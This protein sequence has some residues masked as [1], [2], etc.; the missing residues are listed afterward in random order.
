MTLRRPLA[1]A[2]IAVTGALALTASLAVLPATAAPKGVP[3]GQARPVAQDVTVMTRNIYLGGDITR[4][5]VAATPG[6]PLQTALVLLANANHEL[7]GVV[8]KTDFPARAKLLAREI[9]DTDPD[10]IGLQEVALWRSGPLE[11]ESVGVANAENV[12]YDFL[13]T[14]RRELARLGEPYL[15]ISVQEQ[16]D[17]EG[18][19]FPGLDPAHPEARDVRLTMRDVILKRATSPVRVEGTGSGQYVARIPLTIGPIVYEFI[20]GYNWADVR[21]GAK[22]FRFV[23]THLESQYSIVAYAQAQEL[24]AGPA[25]VTDRPVILVCDCNS[26]PL[27]FSQKDLPPAF[28]LGPKDLP[29]AAPYY[30]LTG[31]LH[32]AWITSGTTDPGFTSGLNETVDEAFPTF[33]HRIDLILTRAAD[34]SAIPAQNPLTVGWD[35]ANRSPSGLWPS[36]HAGVVVS[37]RP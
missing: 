23:N 4:P 13:K 32:D 14:L 9:A 2:A 37:L 21:L 7:A 35:Q 10:L 25:G 31:H 6:L 1:R 36:D 30:L 28:G 11:L 12:D 19:A 22:R 20:R 24:L 15:P 18:P 3:P 34:G 5:L 8:A 29:H 27:D 33:T 16:S 17:V 26:D